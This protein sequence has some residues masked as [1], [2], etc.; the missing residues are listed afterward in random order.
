MDQVYFDNQS[1]TKL[2]ERVFEAMLPYF[3]ENYGN[4]QSMYSLGAISKDAIDAARK[5]VAN[6]INAQEEEIYFTSCGSEANNL[7]VKGAA[8]ANKQKGKH[9]IVSAIEHFSVL[10]C[11]KRLSQEGFEITYLPVDKYGKVQVA[12]LEKAIRKDTILISVQHANTEIGTVQPV[13]EIG[14]VARAKGI[15]FHIDAVCTAGTIAVDVAKLNSDLLTLSGSQFYGPKG[16]AALYIKK[17]VRVIPQIDG[18]IQ[19]N[20][21]RAGTENVPAIVGLGKACEIATAEMGKNAENMIRLRDRI[22]N[23]LPQKIKYIYLNGHITE[24]LP[25]NVN[26]SIEFVEGEAMFM[27]LDAKGILVSSGSACASKA[28]KMSHVLTAAGVDAAV[29]QG[30]ILMSLSKYNTDAEVDYLLENFPKVVER[31]RSMSPLYAYFEKTGQRKPAGPGTDYE[32]EHDHCE[33]E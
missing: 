9:I 21:R 1:N 24:R 3:K 19:E 26:F 30:S 15:L 29:G 27:M 4:P 16:A 23:E 11:A 18:G 8:A 33:T 12:E 5:S 6:L 10:N 14:R 7:A 25:G 31:L 17:G 20:G 13:E 22:I 28:L 2:D 32:H